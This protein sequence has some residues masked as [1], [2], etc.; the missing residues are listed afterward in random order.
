LV[1]LVDAALAEEEAFVACVVAVDA[2]EEAL[3][4]LVA[5][6]CAWYFAEYSPPA[7]VPTVL[8]AQSFARIAD[9]ALSEACDVAVEALAEALLAEVLALD[10]DVAAAL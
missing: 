1:A 9:A 10:A 8:V 4:A 2:E 7:T 3:L 5:D 6:A